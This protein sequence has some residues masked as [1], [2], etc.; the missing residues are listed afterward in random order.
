LISFV[1]GKLVAHDTDS[2]VIDVHG[3]GYEVAL[4]VAALSALPAVGE[5]ALVHT[6]T[7]VRE[8]AFQLF[9]FVD[10]AER[11]L[12]RV[13]L[14]VSGVGPK[15]A[16]QVLA[17]MSGGDL[18]SAIAEGDS[19]RLQKIPGVGK[20][21]AERIVVDLRDKVGKMRGILPGPLTP[22]RAA[23][24]A[25]SAL[26]DLRSAL[27]NLGYRPAQVERAAE[28]VSEAH[29]GAPFEILLREALKVVTS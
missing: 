4:S 11:S 23:P 1:K 13:L 7:H 19:K 12:F 8:D 17:G 6:H 2:A 24:A 28:L 5:E 15:L 21:T 9:G 18:V 26:D 3:V 10:P 14:G 25:A 20:R 16:M 22:T 27:A 29:P